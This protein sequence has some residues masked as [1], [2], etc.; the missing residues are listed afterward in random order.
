MGTEDNGINEFSRN[1]RRVINCSLQRPLKQLQFLK[2]VF[3]TE[4]CNMFFQ[5]AYTLDML[6]TQ[7]SRGF[8]F[9]LRTP[10]AIINHADL[11]QTAVPITD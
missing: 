9:Y 8:H 11:L 6:A 4:I 5:A 10:I 2:S 3:Y 7:Y 1:C